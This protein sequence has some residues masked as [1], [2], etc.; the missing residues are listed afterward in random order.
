MN[1]GMKQFVSGREGGMEMSIFIIIVLAAVAF[2]LRFLVALSRELSRPQPSLHRTFAGV[3][4]RR[5]AR[6]LPMRPRQP[7]PRRQPG[8]LVAACSSGSR[9]AAS[10][11]GGWIQTKEKS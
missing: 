2:L 11:A 8:S 4:A 9:R 10:A 6:L 7:L 1:Q 3:F 5:T